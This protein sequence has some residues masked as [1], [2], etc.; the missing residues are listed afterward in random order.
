MPSILTVPLLPGGLV[1]AAAPPDDQ[2]LVTAK[3]SATR[4]AGITG[5]IRR[6]ILPISVLPLLGCPDPIGPGVGVIPRLARFVNRGRI[7]PFRGFLGFV[8]LGA[9]GGGPAIGP[10]PGEAV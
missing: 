5:A 10:P 7:R 3:G 4:T 2:R 8:F 1:A 6:A 9:A